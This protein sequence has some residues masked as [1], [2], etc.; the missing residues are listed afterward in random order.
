MPVRLKDIA[1]DL[2]VS[3]VTVSKV[4]RN[5]QDIGEET[6][7]RVLDRIKELNYRPNLTA[8]AL[9][10]GRSMT[11]GLIVP[12]LL[13]PFFSLIAKT[14]SGILRHHGYALLLASSDEDPEL[15]AEEVDRMLARSVDAM[16]LASAQT[17]PAPF[18]V[19]EAHNT[20]YV[21]IDRSIDGVAANFVGVDDVEVGR[22]ATEHL[23]AQGCRTIAHIRGDS[24]STATGRLEGYRQAMLQHGREPIVV[25]IGPSADDHGPSGGYEAVTALLAA[26]VRPDGIFCFN[27]PIALGVMRAIL[28]RGLSIPGDVAVVGCGNV[29]YSDF[30]R[31]PLTTVDQNSRSIGEQTAQVALAAIE[32]KNGEPPRTILV[33]PRVVVRASSQRSPLH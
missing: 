4:L 13:H 10:T 3:V 5:H 33:P 19:I 22:L 16:I 9:I 15:E 20:P 7:K 8:R 29:L 23:I 14:L 17:T 24:V 31:V 28:D 18:R 32:G 21:L 12:D 26:E 2:G 25:P 6:R 30:L 11:I 1:K 27:D